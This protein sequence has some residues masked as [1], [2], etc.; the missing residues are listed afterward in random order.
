MTLL[1]R[2]SDVIYVTK[3]ALTEEEFKLLVEGVLSLVAD[4]RDGLL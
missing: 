4:N 3:A 2:L 1:F